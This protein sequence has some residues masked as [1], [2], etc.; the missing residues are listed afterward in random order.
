M[1]QRV[2]V[3]T[4]GH[5]QGAFFSMCS[6]CFNLYVEQAKHDRKY[7]LKMANSYSENMSEHLLTYKS[8]VQ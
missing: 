1:L 7:S 4:A 2:L 5:L 3:L 6:L 8:F